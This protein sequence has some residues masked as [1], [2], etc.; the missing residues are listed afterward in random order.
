MTRQCYEGGARGVDMTCWDR[1][2]AAKLVAGHPIRAMR[3]VQALTCGRAGLCCPPN[4]TAACR[5]PPT[6]ANNKHNCS[7]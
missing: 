4:P 7:A 3:G 1:E 6:D 2:Q 5:D